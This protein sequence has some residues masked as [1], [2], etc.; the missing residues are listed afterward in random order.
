MDTSL[1]PFRS[2]YEQMLSNN[3]KKNNNE[4][5]PPQPAQSMQPQQT[6]SYPVPKRP[7]TSLNSGMNNNNN[8]N[9]NNGNNVNQRAGVHKKFNLPIRGNNDDQAQNDRNM[10][11]NSN[12]QNQPEYLKN[13]EPK[14]IEI[15]ENEVKTLI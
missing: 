10:K 2:A 4:Y 12:D 15:I 7:M 14:L 5:Q 9:N 1:T 3:N 8:N 6:T 11:Q 13:I